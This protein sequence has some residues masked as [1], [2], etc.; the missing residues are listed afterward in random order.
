MERF[1]HEVELDLT[2][3][4]DAITHAK[5]KEAVEQVAEGE[6]VDPDAIATQ[7]PAEGDGYITYG[8]RHKKY[9]RIG[10]FRALERLARLWKERHDGHMVQIGNI[11]K[12]GGGRLS[13]H[14]SHRHGLDVD[15]RPFRKD[16]RIAGVTIHDRNYSHELT[17]E[18]VD[19]LRKELPGVRILFND[20]K[21]VPHK[22]Q[23]YP[24]HNDHLH[25]TFP[26]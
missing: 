16:G 17:A 11:S 13:P 22:T 7:V 10:V 20:K 26:S 25:V 12:L 14:K 5:L 2:G 15:F 8:P 6:R 3:V 18:F 9:T 21:L 23:Q 1:Q 24:G 19:L 4:L